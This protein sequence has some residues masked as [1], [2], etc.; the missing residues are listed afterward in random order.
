MRIWFD[1]NAMRTSLILA[2]LLSG[3]RRMV[4]CF[5]LNLMPSAYENF[6]TNLL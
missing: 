2:A 3:G 5:K 6:C 1:P 4:K